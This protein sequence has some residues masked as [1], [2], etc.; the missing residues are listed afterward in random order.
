MKSDKSLIVVQQGRSEFYL[1]FSNLGSF[2][3]FTLNFRILCELVSSYSAEAL[4]LFV[5]IAKDEQFA[6]GDFENPFSFKT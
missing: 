3:F 2:L 6:E 5:P 4:S 1:F